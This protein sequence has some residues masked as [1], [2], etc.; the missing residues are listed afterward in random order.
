MR[1]FGK[2]LL[3]GLGF[4]LV[5]AVLGFLTSKPAPAQHVVPVRVVN[6]PLPTSISNAVRVSGAVN[7]NV[8]NSVLPISGAVTATIANTPVPVS[9]TVNSNFSNTS[10]TPVFADTDGP[11][12]SGVAASCDV[13]FTGGQVNCTLT[14]VPNNKILVIETISCRAQGPAGGTPPNLSLNVSS[15]P[16]AGGLATGFYYFLAMQHISTD[17]GF[18]DNYGLTSRVTIYAAP[19]TPVFLTGTGQSGVTINGMICAISGHLVNP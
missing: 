11:A 16:V 6:T 7:A 14:T 2:I 12:R 4:G 5:T 3:I 17:P 8:T 13:Q 18:S 19:G 1:K 9:G 15:I 10:S